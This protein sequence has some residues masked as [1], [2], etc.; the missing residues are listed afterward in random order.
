MCSSDAKAESCCQEHERET[1]GILV[2]F[3]MPSAV[4]HAVEEVE[5]R[6]R[7]VVNLPLVLRKIRFV[8]WKAGLF[9]RAFC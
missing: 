5:Q 8:I 4:V 7:K 1:G 3:V 9:S 6:A 2:G